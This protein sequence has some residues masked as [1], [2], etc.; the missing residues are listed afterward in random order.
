MLKELSVLRTA[1]DRAMMKCWAI[2]LYVVVALFCLLDVTS[3]YPL[4]TTKVEKKAHMRYRAEIQKLEK[5]K[6]IDDLISKNEFGSSDIVSIMRTA[7][8]Q[9]FINQ[10]IK[11]G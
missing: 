4:I 9:W 2:L 5:D 8:N 7:H 3:I 11:S 1:Q 6:K 10:Y